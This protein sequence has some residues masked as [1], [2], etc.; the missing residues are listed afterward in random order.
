M[1]D[2]QLIDS[3]CDLTCEPAAINGRQDKIKYDTEF[4]FE[5]Y[6][7][8]NAIVGAIEKYKAGQWSADTLAGWACSYCWILAGGFDKDVKE[9][10]NPFEQ[11]LV[12]TL[13]D[14]LDGL[15]F[16]DECL[17]DIK[18]I[19]S[20]I[21]FYR[22]FDHIWQTRECWYGIYAPVGALDE[23]NSDQYVLIRNDCEKEYMIVFSNGL[24]NN[25]KHQ[26]PQLKYTTARK[27]LSNIDDLKAKG[28]TIL[29]CAEEYL[30]GALKDD[31]D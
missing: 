3:I 17:E 25:Y 11:Y 18:S 21:D 10:F 7:D 28:Y 24:P 13:L 26:D 15:S 6:Y 31:N 16:L 27:L 29:P 20:W 12:W 14:D 1:F 2:K 30:Y 4:P 8:V 9:N 22:I 5:K 19:D 23:L